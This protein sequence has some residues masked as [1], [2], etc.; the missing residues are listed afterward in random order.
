MEAE[1]VTVPAARCAIGEQNKWFEGKQFSSKA[2]FA[3]WARVPR[4]RNSQ[5]WMRRNEIAERLTLRLGMI[6]PRVTNNAHLVC[7]KAAFVVGRG[8]A[9]CFCISVQ[10][11]K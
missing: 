11:R 1:Q 5:F 6:I 3:G 8:T 9:Y 10:L 2:G 7:A 4:E